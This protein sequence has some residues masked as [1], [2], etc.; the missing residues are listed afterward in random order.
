M[1]NDIFSRFQLLVGNESINNLSHKRVAIFG[2]G[3]V[4]GHCIEAIARCG[5]GQI[6]LIDNDTVSSTN[7]NRQIVALHSTIGEYKVD[8][9]KDRILDIN[10]DCI[11]K[12]YKCFYLPET[13]HEF[14][15]NKYD[16]VIDA[17]DTVT[18]KIDLI[19][20]C[21]S[22]KTPI[23]SSMGC[24]NRLD[25]TKLTVTDIYK[26]KNDPLAKIMRHELKKN[27]IKKL[28]VVYSEELPTKPLIEEVE[29]YNQSHSEKKLNIPGSTSFVPSCAGLIIASIVVNELRN[30]D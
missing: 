4:G 16:Y 23:I 2:V 27:H 3:G 26:T 18:A 11:V 8:V 14:D 9:M 17:I 21:Q 20:Q 25:P 7:I 12:T 19:K 29:N 1:T 15:F 13:S 22:T 30:A 10:P 28:K 24:G 6:D 5:V